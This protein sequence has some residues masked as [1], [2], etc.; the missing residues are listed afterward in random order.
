VS[1]ITQSI[2]RSIEVEYWVVD[3][4]GEL[5]EPGQLAS[6]SAGAEREFVRPL[7]EIKTTPCETTSQ[8]REELFD[9]LGAVLDKAEASGKRVVP[10]ATPMAG[11]EVAEIPSERTRIQNEVVGDDF[12]HVRHCAGTHI[13][14]EQQAGHEVDQLNAFVALDPALA[15]VNSSPYYRGERLAASA[16]SMLYRREA[17]DSMPHQGRLWSYID[18]KREWTRRLERRYEEFVTATLDA[19]VDRA[20]L[21]ANFDPE[22]AIWTPVQF[23][24]RFDTVEWRSADAAL[25][26]QVV[27]LADRLAEVTASVRD[28]EVRIEGETG[29]RNEDGVVL[30]SFDAV[31]EYT[32]AAIRDGLDDQG[33]R[34]YL[35]RMG[36]DVAAYDPL[37]AHVDDGPTVTAEAARHRRLEYADVLEQAVRSRRS[38]NAD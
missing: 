16:R 1:D 13:H 22:S 8:L 25:P 24:E 27:Q 37:T 10:L 19:D 11:A 9:R 5:V 20:T 18:D 32:D 30:P 12:R 34:G 26:G 17:Y 31:L 21:E 29:H 35:E 6:A 15:L 14:V 7:L 23:R 33:V 3:E 38:V 28:G 36:F 2:R 4:R